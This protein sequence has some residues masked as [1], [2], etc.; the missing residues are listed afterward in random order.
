VL[1]PYV[2]AGTKFF[3]AKVDPTRVTFENGQAVLSPLRFY[4][5][6]AELS[7]PIRLGLLNSQGEQDLIVNVLAGE[8]YQVANHPNALI[9]TNLRVQDSVRDG[10]ASF[11]EALFARAIREKPGAVVTEYAWDATS[12]DPC[13]T[14]PLSEAELLSLGADVI[15]AQRRAAGMTLTRLHYRYTRDTAGRG[16]DLRARATGGGWARCP[17]RQ[18]SASARAGAGR[19]AE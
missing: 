11:Y 7:L 2:A 12:C 17:G 19:R 13:P 3:V 16:P 8:R 5:D 18:R 15:G 6:A 14:P 9:P 4:Y 10:F 1:A